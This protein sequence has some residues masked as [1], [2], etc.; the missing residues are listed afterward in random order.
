M[1]ASNS[2]LSHMIARLRTAQPQAAPYPHYFLDGFFPDKYYRALLQ[3]LP[4]AGAYRNL[5]EITSLKLEHF[6]FREQRD[7]SDGWTQDLPAE[8]KNFWEQFNTWLFSPALAQAVLESFAG[9]LRARFGAADHWPDVRVE[10]QL[11]RH[12][13]GFFLQPHSDLHTK[14]IV[15]LIYLPA[16]ASAAH[17]GTSLYRPRRPGFSCARSLHHPFED[18][19]KVDTAPFKP[20]SL[21]AFERS[22]R[23]FHGLEPLSPEDTARCHRDLIQYVIYDKAAREAQLRARRAVQSR[24]R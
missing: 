23:S 24:Q 21:L 9:P 2:P 12:R 1:K 11:I 13:A 22:D 17:L 5:F 4:G 6:Q 3:H 19:I 8:M 20:N 15:L 14:L 10:A 18:F 7:L 16:D